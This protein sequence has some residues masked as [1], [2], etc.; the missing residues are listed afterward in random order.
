M[1]NNNVFRW[2]CFGFAAVCT[3]AA[4]WMLNDVRTKVNTRTE[5]LPE[6]IENSRQATATLKELSQDIKDLRTLAGAATGNRDASF[7]RYATDV[8]T[9]IESEGKD[10]KILH[11]KSENTTGKVLNGVKKLVKGEDTPVPVEEWLRSARKEA[12]YRVF[13]AKSK[14]QLLHDLCT[15]TLGEPFLIENKEGQV[16]PLEEWVKERHEPSRQE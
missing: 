1:Q 11:G 4:L 16:Q 6:L 10:C 5:K 12:V 2:V 13:M 3:V 9:L 14:Q 7:V 8:L 15:T